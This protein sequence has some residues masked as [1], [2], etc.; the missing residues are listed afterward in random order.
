MFM[1][2]KL[3][4]IYFLFPIDPT[5]NYCKGFCSYGELFLNIKK[6]NDAQTLG[7][8]W[9]KEIRLCSISCALQPTLALYDPLLGD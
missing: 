8:T 9:L 5:R 4:P 6:I 7:A 2:M 1:V 3:P